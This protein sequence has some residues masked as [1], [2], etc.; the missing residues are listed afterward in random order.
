MCINI[1][2]QGFLVRSSPMSDSI[3]HKPNKTYEKSIIN[4]YIC[5]RCTVVE[6]DMTKP[7]YFLILAFVL[8]FF[9]CNTGRHEDELLRSINTIRQQGDTCPGEALTELE[10]I[11]N[12][13]K[14]SSN[15]IWNKYHLLK[16]RLQDK[17]DI[18]PRTP[19]VIESIVHYFNTHGSDEERMEAYYYQGSVY[20]DLKDFPRSV[21]SFLK[22]LDIAQK[23]KA[24]PCVLLQNTY[25]QLAWLYNGQ[26][27]YDEALKMAKAG[28]RMAEQ[29]KTIDPIYL[30]DV[31]SSA[32]LSGDTLECIKYCDKALEY[33]R[34]D[35]SSLYSSVICELLIR[36]TDK[37]LKT[38][39]EDCLRILRSQK[40][41]SNSHNY[42]RAMARYYEKFVSEDSAALFHERV[43]HESRN[44]YQK[45]NSCEYLMAYYNRKKDYEECGRYSMLFSSYVDSVFDEYMYEQTSRA[46]GEHLYAVSLAKELQAKNKADKYAKAIFI[47]LLLVLFVVLVANILYKRKKKELKDK[48]IA[49]EDA[50]NAI[51][52]YDK[53]LKTS[54][55]F[56]ENQKRKL[57]AIESKT[58]SAERE[59]KQKIKECDHIINQQEANLNVLNEMVVENE[60]ELTKKQMQINELICLSM[61]E[62]ASAKEREIMKKFSDASYGIG[63]ITESDWACLR[64]LV[65]K[66]SPGFT[67]LIITMPRIS[68]LG[69]KTAC[70]KKIGMKNSQIAILTGCPKQ[71]VSDRVKKINAYL[72]KSS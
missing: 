65:E 46:C 19:E 8:S 1:H 13:A 5:T 67:E 7:T 16:I 50:H 71:T 62:N 14:N 66:M 56:V 51:N 44:M 3:G 10:K 58:K 23:C 25:S 41:A 48:T 64:T 52:K 9:S 2:S 20:R 55:F 68:E 57:E 30:M 70:L 54:Q 49:L 38:K 63:H 12:D 6:N 33:I 61:N 11:E 40:D 4:V 29:T 32:V 34:Q 36:Y 69:I 26:Q 27:L 24:K 21:S 39:A 37:K 60:K 35:T 45:K 43:L 42:L 17:S 47:T 18:V 72:E 53:R 15:Y 31:S 28:C 22:V 59:L